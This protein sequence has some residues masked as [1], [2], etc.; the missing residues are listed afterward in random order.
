MASTFSSLPAKLAVHDMKT[1]A[2]QTLWVAA[3]LAVSVACG[4]REQ[5]P[6][7]LAE[8]L[9]AQRQR[10]ARLEAQLSEMERARLSDILQLQEKAEADGQEARRVVDQLTRL[11]S[12]SQQRLSE[13]ERMLGKLQAELRA[14]QNRPEPPPASKAESGPQESDYITPPSGTASDL[15][16]VLALNVEGWKVVTKTNLSSRAVETDKF[17]RDSFGNKVRKVETQ[18][19][20]LYE[21]GYQARFGLQNLTKT[22]KDVVVSAG[23]SSKKLTLTPGE[24]LTNAVVPSVM[25]AS[26]SITVGNQTRRY[27]LA[28]RE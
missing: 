14:V 16:P 28:Y 18:I 6:D 21:Y 17:E 3:L 9:H 22:A 13:Q 7:P 20:E 4:C 2:S 26:L 24:T 23:P 27:P 11:V 1:R 5:K 10:V 12:E 15:F 8:D 25:G 19:Y